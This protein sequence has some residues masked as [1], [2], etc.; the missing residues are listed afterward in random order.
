MWN[1]LSALEQLDWSDHEL[2]R[3]GRRKW[4]YASPLSSGLKTYRPYLCLTNKCRTTI[5]TQ[6]Q[7]WENKLYNFNPRNCKIT[8]NKKE[9]LPAKVILDNTAIYHNYILI[10]LFF[11]SNLWNPFMKKLILLILFL[12]LLSI[13]LFLLKIIFL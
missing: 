11:W 12:I 9:W 7:G 6:S 4:K 10:S 3:D 5:Y 1:H 8:Q 13:W 2:L